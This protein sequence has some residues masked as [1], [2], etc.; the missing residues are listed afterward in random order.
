MGRE[1]QAEEREVL[2]SIFPEEMT[3]KSN[4]Y[5]SCIEV[6]QLTEIQTSQ[7]QN[8]EYWSH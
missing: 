3:G 5:P 2:D 1:D 7:R 4:L 8:S 6:P